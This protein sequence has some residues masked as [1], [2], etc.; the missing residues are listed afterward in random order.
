[1]QFSTL[2]KLIRESFEYEVDGSADLPGRAEERLLA[3]VSAREL[4]PLLR[5][6]AGQQRH[7]DALLA[8]MVRS[9]R[10]APIPGWSA[11]LLEALSPMLVGTSVR[12]L[13]RPSGIA[14]EDVQQQVIVELLHAARHISLPDPSR[15]LKWRLE[16]R[17]VTRT[18]RWLNRFARG[19]G[20][21]VEPTEAERPRYWDQDPLLLMTLRRSGISRENLAL[22]Y[23]S[24]VLGATASELAAEMGVSASAIQSR[25]RRALRRLSRFYPSRFHL[26]SGADS[27]AA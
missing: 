7:E 3:N 9:Y 5:R 16:E 22:L 26:L 21:P 2:S 8:A 18:T 15:R 27:A 6:S 25:Q 11:V 23:Q 4:P 12:F 14:E 24:R 10:R 1:M 17:I 20:E 13:F 19:E